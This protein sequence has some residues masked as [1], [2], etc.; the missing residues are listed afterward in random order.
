G[1]RFGDARSMR[2]RSGHGS[3][4][5]RAGNPAPS[6]SLA[7]GKAPPL[8]PPPCA[9]A[10]FAEARSMRGRLV[11]EV[12][13]I[14][15]FSFCTLRSW[16]APPSLR[17]S[18]RQKVWP[19]LSRPCQRLFATPCGDPLVMAAQEHLGDIQPTP[20]GRSGVDRSLQ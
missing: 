15:L 14:E 13:A 10:R 6:S 7:E 4:R 5:N 18:H 12:R 8:A 3:S 11:T 17:L 16:Q 19:S 20:A 9:G 1:A 2:G